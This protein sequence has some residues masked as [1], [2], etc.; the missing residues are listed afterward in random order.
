MRVFPTLLSSRFEKVIQ[1]IT[2]LLVPITGPIL[3]PILLLGL[4]AGVIFSFVGGD[5][6]G[7]LGNM[8]EQGCAVRGGI[9]KQ[10]NRA[11]NRALYIGPHIGPYRALYGPI[12]P[13]MKIHKRK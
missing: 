9:P 4:L 10:Q 11:Q 1:N 12:G 3:G 7:V 6:C 2:V 8:Q 5:G 13:Y